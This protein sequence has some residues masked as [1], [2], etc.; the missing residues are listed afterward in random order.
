MLDLFN[1][2]TLLKLFF[3]MPPRW[4]VT[5]RY[6]F[7][8]NP[9]GL[10]LYKPYIFSRK[11][12]G[13][14]ANRFD[15]IQRRLQFNWIITS[16]LN[17]PTC[18]LILQLEDGCS[19]MKWGIFV[20]NSFLLSLPES[21]CL[22]VLSLPFRNTACSPRPILH[23]HQRFQPFPSVRRIFPAGLV[24]YLC[25]STRLKYQARNEKIG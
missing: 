17:C 24:G 15:P 2:H 16:I 18:L 4:I 8:K 19:I 20:I 6:P 10:G 7:V 12:F 9:L 1:P 25:V 11:I 14:L 5:T 21:L 22:P 23:V 3:G 13:F